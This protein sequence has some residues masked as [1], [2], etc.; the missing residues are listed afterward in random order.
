MARAKKTVEQAE[1]QAEAT[2][3]ETWVCAC[4]ATAEASHKTY[5]QGWRLPKRVPTCPECV[6]RAKE[7]Q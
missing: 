5:Q 7:N 3:V 2:T 6:K 4:G 1:Q